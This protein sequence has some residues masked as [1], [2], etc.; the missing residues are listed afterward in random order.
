MGRVVHQLI[1][2]IKKEK[3]FEKYSFHGQERHSA[4]IVL[5][6]WPK[7]PKCLKKYLLNLSVQA[8][9]FETFKKK[10]SLGVCVSYLPVDNSVDKVNPT[11]PE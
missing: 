9:M 10:L 7:F 6:V 11:P 8:Q 2:L 5:K 1:V 3:A 4:M